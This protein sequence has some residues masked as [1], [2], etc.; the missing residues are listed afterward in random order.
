MAITK[1]HFATSGAWRYSPQFAAPHRARTRRLN[2]NARFAQCSAKLFDEGTNA[3]LA[4]GLLLKHKQAAV[5]H[6]HG[7]S[8][9]TRAFFIR[10]DW[11]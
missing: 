3:L 1:I 6:A 5:Q 4:N 7:I 8:F 10:T 2:S 11:R 9:D